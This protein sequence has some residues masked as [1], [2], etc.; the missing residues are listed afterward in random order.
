MKRGAWGFLLLLLTGALTGRAQNYHAVE[1]SPFA[2]S[3]GVANNPASIVGTPYPWDIT[4]FSLQ[5]KNTTNAAVVHDVSLLH[6]PQDSV[7]FTFKGGTFK[8]YGGFNYN[9]HLLNARFALDRKQAIAFGVNLRGYTTAKTGTFTFYDSLRDKDISAFFKLNQDADYTA[10]M[11]SS[12]WIELFATYSRTLWDDEYG[13]MNG[14]ITVRGMRGIGGAFAQLGGGRILADAVS[15]RTIYL[16]R[17]ASARY[18]YSSNFDQWQDSKSTTRNLKDFLGHTQAGAA[19]DLGMEYYV[20]SQA[21]TN[22][23]D[24]DTYDEYEWKIGVSLLDLGANRYQFGTQSRSASGPKTDVSD[25]VL[26]A[27]LGGV[28]SLANF[29]DSLATMVDNIGTLTGQF[30]VWNPTRLVINVDRPLQD[31]FS[32]N[33]NLT[34]N[35]AGSNNGNAFFAKDFNLLSV[36]PRWETKVLG[37]YLPMLVTTNGRFWIGGAF[38]AG[39]LLLGVHNWANIFSKEKIQNGGFYLALQIRPG[40]GFSFKENKKYSCPKN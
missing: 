1:G 18:G 36:T 24:E 14:G 27:K 17:A 38:K 9:V 3:L 7:G 37:A 8:R 33:A 6:H 25:S 29:N 12:N 26:Q 40:N 4:V 35:L 21:V 5:V 2:G 34:V 30:T 23:N 39:P 22:F 32:V 10:N 15:A 16:L 13:R 19:I 11:V 20:K 28:S 31:H